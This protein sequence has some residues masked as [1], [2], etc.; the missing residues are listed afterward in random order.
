MG[1]QTTLKILID[2]QNIEDVVCRLADEINRDYNGK[3]LTVIGVLCGSFI[4]LADLVRKLKMP[5]DVD[6]V[7]LSSYGDG[8]ETTE[9][10]HM[11]KCPGCEL[12][13]REVLIVEDIT[14]TGLTSAFL[15][16][17]L[18]RYKPASVKL[19]VLLD[20]PARRRVSL[21]IDYLGLTVPD[22]FLVGYGLDYAGKYRNL[23]DICIL[24]DEAEC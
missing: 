19:C 21:H 14:D 1:S 2:S 3:P 11:T 10:I 6:F 23:T 16:E 8:R 13:G 9:H 17:H 24:E 20:K 4:F 7:G 15:T 18:K 12:A 22:E 5:L